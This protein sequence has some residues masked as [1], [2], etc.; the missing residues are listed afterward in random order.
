MTVVAAVFADFEATFLGGPCCLEERIGSRS[1]IGHTLLRLSRV[2]G[3]ERRCLFV[4]PVH[5]G[6]ARESIRAAGGE[7]D[8][9]VLTLDDGARPRRALIRS[10]RKWHLAGWRG[11]VCGATW[12]D[13]FVE[14]R[15]AAQVLDHYGADAVLCLSA[16]QPAL[17][18]GIASAMVAHATRSPDEA[19]FVFTQA[20]P[21]L[22]GIVL[23]RDLTRELL[24]A[25]V[26]IGLYLSYR[27]EIP[28]G[29]PITRPVCL[30]LPPAISHVAA[31]LTG[32]T[33]ESRRLLARAFDE[34]GED[35]QAR[36]LCEWLARDAHAA[37]ADL[38]AEVEIELTTADPLPETTLRPRGGRVRRRE[39]VSVEALERVARELARLDDR[40]VVLGGFGDP[41]L[42]PRFAEVCA[43]VR[44]AGV[45]GLAVVTPLLELSD[46]NLGALLESRVDVVQVL[47]DGHSAE[48]YR[49]VNRADAFDRVRANI[50]RIQAARRERLSPQ[51]LLVPTI[52][53]CA[54]T[55]H[56]LDAFFDHWIRNVGTATIGGY[57]GYGGRMP[58]DPLLS[59]TPPIREPCRRLGSRLT[60]LADGSAVL[61]SEDVDG[62]Q[63][64]GDWTRE[65]LSAIWTGR[66]R[67]RAL[68][69]HARLRFDGLAVCG[70]CGEWFRT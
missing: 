6:P 29:D 57:S 59:M 27:P 19:R 60:L 5:E 53:R 3:L 31:R 7:R 44:R 46:A 41:L 9:D 15:C 40:L 61:C 34:L 43:T 36:E 30:Q 54:A 45:C 11:H 4:R 58:P 25:D 68:D 42:H 20:P 47:L 51:P 52:T 8:I 49:T 33:L 64:V 69:A 13:E 56:E 67:R 12:F 16:C 23:G 63:G 37:N 10:A 2:E 21:G 50:D 24:Q 38:P 65:P 48:T 39:V 26:P 62:V 28:Q 18:P 32:D 35:C 22:A 1:L 14:P 70:S 55:L 17:D 66:A